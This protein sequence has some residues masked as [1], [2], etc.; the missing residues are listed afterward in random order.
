MRAHGWPAMDTD[1][2]M[3]VYPIGHT[4]QDQDMTYAL[5][6]FLVDMRSRSY[7]NLGPKNGCV[8]DRIPSSNPGYNQPCRSIRVQ[9]DGSLVE[10]YV[11]TRIQSWLYPELGYRIV[12]YDPVNPMKESTEY[13]PPGVV[14]RRYGGPICKSTVLSLVPIEHRGGMIQKCRSLKSWER[15]IP[16]LEIDLTH[17]TEPMSA[18]DL[19]LMVM[20]G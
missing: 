19:M 16:G 3:I 18:Q 7:V 13:R 2:W 8:I 14:Q 11:Y 20:A 17:P 15:V 1:K 12:V 5:R 9:D 4:I 6:F 10:N